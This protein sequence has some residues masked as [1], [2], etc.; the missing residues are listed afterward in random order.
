MSRS[1]CS[2]QRCDAETRNE[3]FIC[4]EHVVCDDVC[5]CACVRVCVLNGRAH[6]PVK[7]GVC[8]CVRACANVYV[9]VAC[10]RERACAC[11][12]ACES[13]VTGDDVRENLHL[14]FLIV[15]RLKNSFM[16]LVP[17]ICT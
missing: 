9:C 13:F 2:T 11:V 15:N 1:I 4:A 5:V 14:L 12:H 6:T 17:R 16:S 3:A 7:M 8:I 10:V